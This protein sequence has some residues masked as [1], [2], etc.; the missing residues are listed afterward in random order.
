MQNNQNYLISFDY[1]KNSDKVMSIFGIKTLLGV[2]LVYVFFKQEDILGQSVFLLFIS[3]LVIQS[4]MELK[5]FYFIN[6]VAL[7]EN[8]LILLKNEVINS[9]TLFSNLTF[10][11]TLNAID[12]LKNIE[13]DFYEQDTRKHLVKLKSNDIDHNLFNDFIES[14]S[15]FSDRDKSDFLTTSHNQLLSFS[16]DDMNEQAIQG[17]FVKHTNN[18]FFTKYN[19]LIAIYLTI[20]VTVTFYLLRA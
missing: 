8:S 19:F 4:Y 3:A 11:V 12:I 6:K 18:A 17:E 10:K 7:S 14:L 1:P 2:F 5:T 13:I 15:R 9:K 20:V 16:L